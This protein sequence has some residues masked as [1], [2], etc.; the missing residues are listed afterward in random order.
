MG[1]LARLLAVERCLEVGV[2]TGYSSLCVARALPPGGRL[3]ACDVSEEWTAIARRFWER[4]GVAERIE[5]RLG[6]GAKT[7]RGLIESGESGR[8]DFAFLDADKEGQ[9]DYFEQ[10]LVLLRRGGVVAIDNAFMGGEVLDAR[11]G[12][13]AEVRALTE[14]VFAD[15]RVD[16]SLVPIGDGVLLARKR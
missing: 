11:D 4:A 6:P 9:A 16:A 1:L 15:R 13:A 7:L 2:F 12:A 5:L 8:F 14:R 3:V 10:C